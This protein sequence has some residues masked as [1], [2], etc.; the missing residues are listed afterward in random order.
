MQD[1]VCGILG[2]LS[3]PAD[4][5]CSTSNYLIYKVNESGRIQTRNPIV[6]QLIRYRCQEKP[7]REVSIGGERLAVFK[8]TFHPILKG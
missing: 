1:I 6:D 4:G 7:G 2:G 8:P 3:F 5:H